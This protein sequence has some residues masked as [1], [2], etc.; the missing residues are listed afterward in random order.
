MS[1]RARQRLTG[2]VSDLPE[3]SLAGLWASHEPGLLN[4]LPV[5]ADTLLLPDGRGSMT[6]S[7]TYPGSFTVTMPS[8]EGGLRLGSLDAALSGLA[9]EPQ[10]WHDWLSVSPM[11]SSLEQDLHRF[12]LEECMQQDLFHLEMVCQQPRTHLE[13]Y[14]ERQEVSRARQ[15]PVRAINY[16]ASHTEDW[17]ARTLRGVRPR[18]VIA[19]VRDDRYDIYENRV[20]VRLVDHLSRYVRR[21]IARIKELLHSLRTIDLNAQEPPSGMHWRQQRIYRLWGEALDVTA[22]QLLA[23]ERLDELAG[24]QYR[25]ERLRVSLLYSMVSP[26]AQVPAQLRITNILGNDPHYRRVARLWQSWYHHAHIGYLSLTE[27]QRTAQ[28]EAQQFDRYVRLLLIHALDQFEFLPVTEARIREDHKLALVGPEGTLSLA[29]HPDGTTSLFRGEAEVLRVI[30]SPTPLAEMRREELGRTVEALREVACSLPCQAILLYPGNASVDTVPALYSVPGDP[31]HL[32][33]QLSCL[34]VSPVDLE[35]VERLARAL[36][37]VLTAQRYLAYPPVIAATVTLPAGGA[38]ETLSKRPTGDW[39]LLGPIKRQPVAWTTESRR[40]QQALQDARQDLKDAAAS[41]ALYVRRAQRA[42]D[43]AQ[44]HL[45]QWEAFLRQVEGAEASLHDLRRCPVC[46]TPN[47][48]FAAW[49]DQQFNCECQDCGAEWSLRHC[50]TCGDF[51]PW[52]LPHLRDV[53]DIQVKPGWAD[54]L[55]GRDI[56]TLPDPTDLTAFRCPRTIS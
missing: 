39:S 42:V 45:T 55:Y 19:N 14:E 36:R 40:L 48:D 38:P 2:R 22:A 4:G 32:D 28:H 56:L 49:Q 46:G 24:F 11:D 51:H 30:A 34:P 21:R 27:Q 53:P 13:I 44:R 12:P 6:W 17:E 5:D 54:R 20:A 10:E 15:I 18:R 47:A 3:F 43:E 35:S 16:L 8:S 9:A 50:Q 33:R 31:Q 1:G 41:G 25:L 29:C 52:L 23:S 26:K 37:W 7:G